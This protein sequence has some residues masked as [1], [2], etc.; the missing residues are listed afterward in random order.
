MANI[1]IQDLNAQSG[2]VELNT[3]ELNEVK[4]GCPICIFLVAVAVG[5]LLND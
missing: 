3:S 1:L 2:L 5:Y 4:G